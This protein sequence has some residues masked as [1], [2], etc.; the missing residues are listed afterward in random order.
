MGCIKKNNMKQY[1]SILTVREGGFPKLPTCL[2]WEKLDG[3]NLRF[4]YKN[5]KWDKYGT[6]HQLFDESDIIFGMAIKIFQESL[7]DNI[8]EILINKKIQHAVVFCEY[9]GPKS[10]AGVHSEED[11]KKNQMKLVPF[12]LYI[13]KQGILPTRNFLKLFK[14]IEIPRIVYEGNF[15]KEFVNDVENGQYDVFEGVVAKGGTSSKNMWSR[16]I[17]TITYLKKLKSYE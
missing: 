10:F 17:K 7:Q 6:R 2:A 5:K 16:K 12:D 15:N 13:Y 8:T 1:P 14:N 3:S 11:I 4:E 9:Y